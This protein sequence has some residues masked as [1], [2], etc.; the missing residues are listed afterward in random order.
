MKQLQLCHRLK[1]QMMTFL[2]LKQSRIYSWTNLRLNLKTS[3][4]QNQ[5]RVLKLT[6]LIQA[7]ANHSLVKGNNRS[8]MLWKIIMQSRVLMRLTKLRVWRTKKSFWLQSV[9]ML[10]L[11]KL[12]YPNYLK[13]HGLKGFRKLNSQ[14][15]R[16]NLKDRKILQLL[17]GLKRKAQLLKRS[18]C[19]KWKLWTNN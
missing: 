11:L 6:Q 14:C 2:M 19:W 5:T 1:K 17:Q 13:I 8:K 7:W 12:I 3:L 9:K 4:G 18:T 16:Q 15:Q 10:T